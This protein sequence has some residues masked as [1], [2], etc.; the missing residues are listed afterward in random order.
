MSTA[1]TITKF[2]VAASI[3]AMRPVVPPKMLARRNQRTVS[4]RDEGL[5]VRH[6]MRAREIG[7]LAGLIISPELRPFLPSFGLS[8]L[9]ERHASVVPLEETK[10]AAPGAWFQA[11]LPAEPR[12]IESMA[13]RVAAAG[14]RTL[15]LT[16]DVP[17]ASN[18]EHYMRSGFSVPL[19]PSARLF[20]Q[21]ASHPRWLFGTA[22]RTLLLHGVPH[23]ENMDATRGPPF[24]S[25]AATR[26]IGQR[27]ALSWESVALVRKLWKGNLVLK[28]ILSPED[29]ML[30]RESGVDGIIVSNHGGRQLD[31]AAAPLRVLPAICERSNGMAVMLDGGIRR[32][33]DVLKALGLGASFVFLGRPFLYAAVAG[34]EEGICHAI[35]L[36]AN[37]IDRDMA[38]AG[39]R[40]IP[41]FSAKHIIET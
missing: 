24:L 22:F 19:R 9:Q 17:V 18:R 21:G 3:D 10:K 2:H 34:G 16:V 38:L 12:R 14:Y 26:L 23:F 1:S 7:A 5:N 35:A 39:V 4:W 8:Q 28:G 36:L 37:E 30:A 33:T 32:G 11:Y 40:S 25:R 6:E 15:V 41:E 31:S 13:D 29:A 27:D 20:W